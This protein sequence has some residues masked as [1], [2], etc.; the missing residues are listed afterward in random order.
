LRRDAAVLALFEPETAEPTLEVPHALALGGGAIQLVAASTS[1]IE[2]W[3]ADA[4]RRPY[5]ITRVMI[6]APRYQ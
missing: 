5:K 1:A 3:G 6:K 2:S 4:S